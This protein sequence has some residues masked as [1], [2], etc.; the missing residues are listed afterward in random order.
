MNETSKD[1]EYDVIIVGS[2]TC[3]ASIARELTKKNKN[4]LILEKG[5]DAPL[6]ESIFSMASI[7]NEIPVAN[8]SADGKN[9]SSMRA[10][11][12]G[13]SS[14]LY[15]AVA[16]E[17]PMQPFLDLGIDLS[18]EIEE[19]KKELPTTT[20][21]DELL[22]DQTIRFRNSASELGYNMKKKNMLIDLDKCKYGYSYDAKW[23]A[24]D[25]VDEAVSQGTKLISR[26]TVTK[27]IVRNGNA[28]G[29]EYKTT[30]KVDGT[31]VHKVFGQKVIIA[32]GVLATPL[33]LRDSGLENV[34]KQGFYC[35]P[36]FALMGTLPEL[37][38][39]DN[40]VASMSA[41]V[42]KGIEIGDA[43]VSRGLYRMM[44]LSEFKLSKLF[45]FSKTIGVG[46]FVRDELSGVFGD[47]G[48]YKKQL[49]HAELKKIEKGEDVA[50][51][52]L[53]NAGAKNI[54]KFN[55]GAGNVGGVIRVG[56]L[57]DLNL[58]T[59]IENLYVCDG[60]VVP[61]T[62]RVSPTL[63]LVCLSKRLSKHLLSTL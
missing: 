8:E 55:H 3:G 2:G 49:T 22:S 14:A 17:P 29:V 43:N 41:E 32:A 19:V 33:I 42:E 50:L 44:M 58:K 4:V 13:G 6:K 26:A 34:G 9:L 23:K 37:K 31:K 11:T 16:D 51:D 21:P 35:D 63:T 38:A 15:F 45:S 62:V 54:F 53:K 60:S 24:R 61:E 5:G 40:F 7:V 18:S 48:N 59:E 28:V 36:N 12:K 57:L 52:I 56:E 47:D 20:L 27:V 46:G 39:K 1:N 25:F 10:I 30:K